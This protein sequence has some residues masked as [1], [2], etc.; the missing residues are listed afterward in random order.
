MQIN[1]NNDEICVLERFL[2]CCALRAV[3]L[4]G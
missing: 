2:N 1:R 3:Y 4:R